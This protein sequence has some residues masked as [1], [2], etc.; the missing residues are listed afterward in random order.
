M[1][2]SMRSCSVGSVS[3]GFSA[4]AFISASS[5]F[6]LALSPESESVSRA[7]A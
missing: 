1:P 7:K 4:S 6:S 2:A 3:G 5:S